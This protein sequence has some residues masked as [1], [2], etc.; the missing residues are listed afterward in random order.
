MQPFRYLRPTRVGNVVD[1]LGE[2]GDAARLLAGGT[3]LTVALRHGTITPRVVIDVKRVADLRPSITATQG[4]LSISATTVM[5]DVAWHGLVRSRFPAL[6]EAA[7]VVGSIQIRNRAT[8]VGNIC[9][10]SPAADTLPVLCVHGASVTILGPD[11]MREL[12]VVDFITGNR[13]TELAS[14][15]FVT[16]VNI[17]IPKQNFGTSFSRITRRRGVDLA[18]VNLCCGVDVD[19]VTSFAFGAVAVR[20]L[21]V[22]DTSGAL[23]D[24]ATS[25]AEKAILLDTLVS[26]ATPI[27]DVRASAEYRSAMLRVLAR[28]ALCKATERLRGGTRHD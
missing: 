17:P 2:H 8:L 10:A 15:E 4:C 13:Q 22:R 3:D 24:P 6:A 1:L 11:G 23:A 14:D 27:S 16:A 18:T 21:L 26:K 20:P 7:D 28:R 25:A 5:S 12:L 19:G 9:N